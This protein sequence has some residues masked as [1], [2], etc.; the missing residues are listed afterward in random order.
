MASY[1]SLTPCTP[2]TLYG[3]WDHMTL[4]PLDHE[5]GEGR[6]DPMNPCVPM[7]GTQEG[8]GTGEGMRL[9]G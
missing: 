6:T 4:A 2:Y 8:P 7:V 5:L 3:L 1:P 9:R